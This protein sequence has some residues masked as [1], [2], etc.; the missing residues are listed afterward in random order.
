MLMS[1]GNFEELKKFARKQGNIKKKRPQVGGQNLTASKRRRTDSGNLSFVSIS[2]SGEIDGFSTDEEKDEDGLDFSSDSLPRSFLSKPLVKRKYSK[3]QALPDKRGS[4]SSAPTTHTDTSRGCKS[5]DFPDGAYELMKYAETSKQKTGIVWHASDNEELPQVFSDGSDSDDSKTGFPSK[6][7]GFK[8]NE[9][10]S[11]SGEVISDFHSD[12]DQDSSQESFSA[13]ISTPTP[14][15]VSPAVVGTPRTASEWLKQVQQKSPDKSQED[16]LPEERVAG[17]NQWDSARKKKKFVRSGL[18]ER[19]QYIIT[20]E[21]SEIAFWNH[22]V[23]DTEKTSTTGISPPTDG[24]IIIQILSDHLEGS[25]HLTQCCSWCRDDDGDP[26]Q[27]RI[28]FVLFSCETWKQFTLQV[29]AL[30]KIHPPWQKLDIPGVGCPVLLCPYFCH[31]LI[32]DQLP[33]FRFHSV[34]GSRMFIPTTNTSP[35]TSTLLQSPR[36]GFKPS[37]L[38]FG[39]AE[40]A[41][42]SLSK[43]TAVDRSLTCSSRPHTSI[44]MAIESSGG[45]S[46]VPVTIQC[47]VQRV[48][49][50][51][52]KLVGGNTDVNRKSRSPLLLNQHLKYAAKSLGEAEQEQLRWALLVQDIHGVCAE[53]QV[54]SEYQDLPDWLS[55]LQQGKGKVF[56]FLQVRIQQ[57]TNRIRSPGLFS[58]IESLCSSKVKITVSAHKGSSQIIS[59]EGATQTHGSPSR[60]PSFCYVLTVEDFSQAAEDSSS[61]EGFLYKPIT[62][63]TLRDVL[64]NQENKIERISVLC[65]LMYCRLNES[66]SAIGR[67]QNSFELFLTDHSAQSATELDET[68]VESLSYVKV[69]GKSQ[70]V[71]P[72]ELRE[73][74]I[75]NG[76]VLSLQDL[77]FRAQAETQ[78]LVADTY[79]LVRKAVSESTSVDS[80]FH[81]VRVPQ[82]QIDRLSCL[83]PSS[84]P[85]LTRQSSCGYLYRVEGVVIGIDEESACCWLA[86]DICGNAEITVKQE[87]SSQFFCSSCNVPVDSPQTK[88]F[89]AVLLKVKRFPEASVRVTLQQN[90]IDRLLRVSYQDSDQGYDIEAVLGKHLPPMS[91]YVTEITEHG[92]SCSFCLEEIQLH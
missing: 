83:K 44:L 70:H 82:N 12:S 8:A 28:L 66:S 78:E 88:T 15:P 13:E 31:K 81:E 30:V 75:S 61:G 55:C 2:D 6:L 54:P 74:H 33:A 89:L 18:A 67:L 1:W 79:S 5:C 49:R 20:R 50:K 73:A 58:I 10:T 14:T 56:V 47:L 69:V 59:Q 37:K 46:G 43:V 68:T 53:I 64:H 72:Q 45:C 11:A 76:T 42:S 32:A 22:R 38:L 71:L 86:C 7:S 25:V 34:T 51:K 27:E 17:M 29:G 63:R 84:L 41:L 4:T 24:S 3:R 62:F 91:C 48:Y 16:N 36:K 92:T 77:L 19:L 40:D 90:T 35:L 23:A 26:P 52:V 21:K 85:F 9:V 80:S 87:T 60:P 39:N 65:K 57:R